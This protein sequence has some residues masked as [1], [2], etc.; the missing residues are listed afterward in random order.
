MKLF[1]PI[2][3]RKFFYLKVRSDS[4]K[5]AKNSLVFLRIFLGLSQKMKMLVSTDLSTNIVYAMNQFT[6]YFCIYHLRNVFL[7]QLSI[8]KKKILLRI[9][10][11]VYSLSRNKLSKTVVRQKEAS[12]ASMTPSYKGSH[13]ITTWTRKVGQVVS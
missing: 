1:M 8:K 6:K 10:V 5:G 4:P 11:F 9:Y 2:L 13:S 3:I 12:L 7:S